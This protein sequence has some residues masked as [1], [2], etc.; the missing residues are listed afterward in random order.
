ME[1]RDSLRGRKGSRE[2]GGR[3]KIIYILQSVPIYFEQYL[4]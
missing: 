2:E 1:G 4:Y 3:A